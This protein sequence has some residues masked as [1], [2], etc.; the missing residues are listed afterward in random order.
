MVILTNHIFFH[1]GILLRVW[2]DIPYYVTFYRCSHPPPSI[3][4]LFM[5]M[6]LCCWSILSFKPPSI[7]CL[8][9]FFFL[10]VHFFF[11][12]NG[13]AHLADIFQEIHVISFWSCM[14]VFQ[15]FG[16]T[17]F[18]KNASCHHEDL[19]QLDVLF[20]RKISCNIIHQCSASRDVWDNEV[21]IRNCINHTKVLHTK[22]SYF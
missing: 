17:C 2:L 15:Y 7:L 20:H 16:T 9:S 19:Y 12:F 8:L 22:H 14:M 1:R 4:L 5:F 11:F 21:S 18:H 3:S 6:M 13:I 10:M